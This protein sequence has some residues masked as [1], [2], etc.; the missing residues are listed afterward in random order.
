MV[1]IFVDHVSFVA[2]PTPCCILGAEDP[3][4]GN[5]THSCGKL[6][7]PLPGCVTDSVISL[8]SASSLVSVDD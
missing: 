6:V 8:A 2:A 4:T 7:P 5:G 1:L 3:L